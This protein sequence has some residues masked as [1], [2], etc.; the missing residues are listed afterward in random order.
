MSEMFLAGGVNILFAL[1]KS[2]L[3]LFVVWTML[4]IFDEASDVSFKDDVLPQLKQGN[5]G[6]GLYYGCRFLGAAILGGLTYIVP[7]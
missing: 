4:R 1:G 3:A 2:V 5:I 7:L 6:L